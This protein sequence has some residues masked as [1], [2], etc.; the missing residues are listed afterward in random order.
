M[1]GIRRTRAGNGLACLEICCLFGAVAV[2]ALIAPHTAF[3][4]YGGMRLPGIPYPYMR[5]NPYAG[6]ESALAWSRLLII[7]ITAATWFAIGAFF[8]PALKAVLKYVFLAPCLL[9]GS[10]TRCSAPILWQTP[11]LIL[12]P[13]SPAWLPSGS[14][15]ARR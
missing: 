1:I 13:S 12:S 2:L 8:S 4:Q 6:D 14:P 3:A 5:T 9:S 7:T 10:H 11:L 15:S